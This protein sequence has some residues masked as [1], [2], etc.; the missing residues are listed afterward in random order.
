MNANAVPIL[1][2]LREGPVGGAALPASVC[3]DKENSM[4]TALGGLR[5]QV[6]GNPRRTLG[7]SRTFSGRGLGP[8]EHTDHACGASTDHRRQQRLTTLPTLLAHF[9]DFLSRAS[10][11]GPR[12]ECEMFIL[13]RHDGKPAVDK[14][15]VWPTQADREQF[16]Y[17]SYSGITRGGGNHLSLVSAQVW[18]VTSIP[19]TNGR[20]LPV[21]PVTNSASSSAAPPPSRHSRQTSRLQRSKPAFSALK[22]SLRDRRDRPGE[23]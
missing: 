21:L 3:L 11:R 20:S 1:A 14:F 16:R 15:K 6:H 22:N 23:R 7:R 18:R 4:G 13:I 17:P 9:G 5:A 12:Q 8:E 2:I 19:G 10:V